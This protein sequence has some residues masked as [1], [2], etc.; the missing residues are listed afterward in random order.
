MK[1]IK[2]CW[3]YLVNNLVLAVLLIMLVLTATKLV[4][5]GMVASGS[6]EPTLATGEFFVS[7]AGD[8]KRGDVVQFTHPDY[9]A[10]IMK[11]LIGL[12]GE[13]VSIKDGA[14][15]I[16]GE[17]LD[18]TEYLPEGLTTTYPWNN[19]GNMSWTVPE[20]SYFMLGDNRNNSADSRYWG[21]NAFVAQENIIGIVHGLKAKNFVHCWLCS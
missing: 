15:Y 4:A 13:T 2:K 3:D 11:R 5:F 1:I 12:P 8:E 10:I 17:L 7:I 14:V 19:T 6:M 18:E 21:E 20:G 16:D 9:D